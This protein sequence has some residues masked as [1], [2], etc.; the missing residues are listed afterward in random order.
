VNSIALSLHRSSIVLVDRLDRRHRSRLLFWTI[1]ASLGCG[2]R[3]AADSFV[4]MPSSV[5]VTA[6]LTYSLAV[7]APITSILLAFHWFREGSLLM[8][9]RRR[10]ARVGAW[11]S[12]SREEA[13]AHR[14]YGVSGLMASL[15]VG[16]LLN[17]PVRT[18]EFFAAMPLLGARP[19]DWFDTLYHLMVADVVMV[20]SLYAVAAVAALRKVPHFPRLLALAWGL[21]ILMQLVIA[22]VMGQ[23]PDMPPSVAGALVRLLDGNLD[24][25]LISMAIWVPYLL[26]SKRVNVTFRHRVPN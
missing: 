25:V 3:L 23:S 15:I 13:Q 22:Y 9:P 18:L 6:A 2:A 20:A 14:L 12:V 11:R 24:K 5:Q 21:D 17:I 8:H 7:G 16:M 19:P 1:V 10:L 4:A 26:L